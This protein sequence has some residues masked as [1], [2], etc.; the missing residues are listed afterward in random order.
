MSIPDPPPG[1]EIASFTFAISCPGCG[2]PMLPGAPTT[3]S[4][5]HVAYETRCDDCCDL[6]RIEVLATVVEPWPVNKLDREARRREGATYATNV[7]E[8]GGFR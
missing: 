4:P 8:T 2:G 3:A 6:Y 5:D 1:R 7:L